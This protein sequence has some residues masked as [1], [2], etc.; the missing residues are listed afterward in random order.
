[1]CLPLSRPG[2]VSA[3]TSPSGYASTLGVPRGDT[4]RADAIIR[5]FAERFARQEW[6]GPWL[7]EIYYDPRGLADADV[8]RASLHAK[9][10]VVDGAR[11]LIGSANFTEAAQLRNIEVGLVV[12]GPETAVAIERHF[13][14]L[15]ERGHLQRLTIVG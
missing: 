2:C 9:C 12:N 11:A 15:I 5:R 3:P 10:V 13:A 14:A 1:M 4:A 7:P 8:G 6:P